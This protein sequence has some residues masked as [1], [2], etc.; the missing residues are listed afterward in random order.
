LFRGRQVGCDADGNIYYEGRRGRP[1]LRRRRWSPMP[2]S[3]R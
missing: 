1:G 3:R 2:A